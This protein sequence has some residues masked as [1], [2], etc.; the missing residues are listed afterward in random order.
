M[1]VTTSVAVLKNPWTGQESAY[2]GIMHIMGTW[3][4]CCDT[5]KKAGPGSFRENM[6]FEQGL[7]VC[8]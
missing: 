7:K 6:I 4:K 1:E 8:M 2:D 5:Q 3:A